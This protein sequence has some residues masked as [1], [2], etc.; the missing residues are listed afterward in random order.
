MAFNDVLARLAQL[1]KEIE[2]EQIGWDYD[3]EA[4]FRVKHGDTFSG[5]LHAEIRN[6]PTFGFHPKPKVTVRLRTNALPQ[7]LEW[8]GDSEHPTYSL[9]EGDKLF[10]DPNGWTLK[11]RWYNRETG[12]A[13]LF[14]ENRQG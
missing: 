14:L 3:R 13:D 10:G 12:I 9:Y 1:G 5:E 2:D 7:S 6:E 8:M 4:V 11:A